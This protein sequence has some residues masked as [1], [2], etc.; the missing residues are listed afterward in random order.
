MLHIYIHTHIKIKYN[1]V[2]ILCSILLYFI[3]LYIFYIIYYIYTTKY[4]AL[5]LVY[6]VA[7]ARMQQDLTAGDL[8]AQESGSQKMVSYDDM[9]DMEYP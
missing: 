7:T 8:T 6:P 2:D 1:I 9:D 4:P 3:I 5:L